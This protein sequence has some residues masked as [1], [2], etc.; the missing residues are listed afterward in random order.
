SQSAG[1]QFSVRAYGHNGFSGT[2]LWIDPEYSV[3]VILLTNRSYFG[4][5]GHM[6]SKIRAPFHNL[7]MKTFFED[8][9]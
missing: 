8:Q 7:V 4:G 1:N 2:S 3:I 5:K 9:S 6:F